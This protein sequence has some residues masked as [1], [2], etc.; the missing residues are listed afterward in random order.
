MW[1][2]YLV[3][4]FSSQILDFCE[5]IHPQNFR[6]TWCPKVTAIWILDWRSCPN[7]E[8]PHVTL[9]YTNILQIRTPCLRTSWNLTRLHGLIL[10]FV[11]KLPSF[12]AAQGEGCTHNHVLTCKNDFL[13]TSH[14]YCMYVSSMHCRSPGM[15]AWSDE[16]TPIMFAWDKVFL[17]NT[18]G[19]HWRAYRRW[20]LSEHR[21]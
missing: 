4:Y 2:F 11:H 8:V 15:L 9:S 21:S 5:N 16:A 18:F 12:N 13:Q 7:R 20:L 14:P 17:S 3:N 6:A 19:E 1:K 10:L